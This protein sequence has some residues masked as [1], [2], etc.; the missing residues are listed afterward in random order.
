[1]IKKE[2]TYDNELVIH[3]DS[4]SLTRQMIR[5]ASAA[6]ICAAIEINT[7]INNEKS[8]E[9]DN[10]GAI[11]FT[12]LKLSKTELDVFT[13]D[14]IANVQ[15]H[16]NPKKRTDV[17]YFVDG[18]PSAYGNLKVHMRQIL[19]TEFKERTKQLINSNTALRKALSYEET[20]KASMK[21]T[22]IYICNRSK[23]SELA[24]GVQNPG[25]HLAQ[26]QKELADLIEQRSKLDKLI[27]NKQMTVQ[28][29]MINQATKQSKIGFLKDEINAIE[30]KINSLNEKMRNLRVEKQDQLLKN[31][32]PSDPSTPVDEADFFHEEIAKIYNE[33][34]ELN[35]QKL[36]LNVKLCLKENK[37]DSKAGFF[38]NRL[39][40]RSLP[41]NNEQPDAKRITQ[42]SSDL[43]NSL[44]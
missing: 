27:L 6:E 26:A 43:G 18:K 41:D 40:K 38:S 7:E 3:L 12:L 9:I 29:L 8:V 15:L 19:T 32:N 21:Q 4:R 42:D 36:D 10:Y 1:M 37:H 30:L 33:I 25:C 39:A 20:Q 44:S 2:L 24:S 31:A 34:K 14:D 22:N 17:R 13:S 11:I 28:E 23:L 35:K 16:M 5:Q